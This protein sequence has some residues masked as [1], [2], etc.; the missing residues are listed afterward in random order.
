MNEVEDESLGTSPGG[1][2]E[3]PERPAYFLSDSSHQC[4]LEGKRMRITLTK[5][6]TKNQWCVPLSSIV[7]LVLPQI[8]ECTPPALGN[9]KLSHL[10]D[11]NACLGWFENQN[12]DLHSQMKL[13]LSLAGAWQRRAVMR[14]PFVLVPCLLLCPFA[15]A[16]WAWMEVG[17]E[18]S[19]PGTV[20]N[21]GR[22]LLG[23]ADVY[24]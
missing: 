19:L 23:L 20:G 18:S 1:G 21:R 15:C 3:A 14:P 17:R 6:V 10:G 7:V 9:G 8:L 11:S 4:F 12:L 22:A 16:C 2:P 24:G 13:Y 5:W